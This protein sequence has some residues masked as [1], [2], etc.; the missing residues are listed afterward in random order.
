MLF[1]G[2]YYL[3]PLE[4]E[5]L[6]WVKML[7]NDP[8]T[9]PYLG[10]FHFINTFKQKKW[11]EKI[12]TDMSQEYTVFGYKKSNLGIVRLTQIDRVNRSMCVGGDI[13]PKHR[14]KG[15]ARSMFV[16]IFKLG[17]EIWGM[18]RL[19]LFVLATNKLALSLYKKVGFK[20]EGKQRQAIF[21]ERKFVDYLMLSL[22]ADEYFAK[23]RQNH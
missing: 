6:A 20:V 22:L 17:F 2:D 18:H 5:D 15:H 11:Y 9:W 23:Y 3:R 13:L 16:L 19:W 12:I 14:G 8:G 10:S 4:E 21:R 1:V 7:R